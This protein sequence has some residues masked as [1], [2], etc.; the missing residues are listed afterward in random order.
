[1]KAIHMSKTNFVASLDN[2]TKRFG[3]H[4]ALDQLSFSLQPGELVAL[5]GANGAGK[6]TAIRHLLGLM[7]PT[8]GHVSLF[9]RPPTD[10]SA[11]SHIG[12]MLQTGDGG[13][14]ENLKVH[15]HIDLFSSYYPQP[16]ALEDTI[17]LAN[18]GDLANIQYK[19]LSGGQRQRVMFALALCGNPD[20]LFLD[21]PTVGLDVES[22]HALWTQI[23]ALIKARKT[24]LLTTHYI[25]EAEQLADRILVMQS[26]RIVAQGTSAEIKAAYNQRQIRCRTNL[27]DAALLATKGVLS[28]RREG[29]MVVLSSSN[30]DI[31]TRELILQDEE[32]ADLNVSQIGLQ[33]AF[34]ALTTDL[35]REH[36]A[37]SRI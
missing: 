3:G 1:M 9:G 31:T 35:T 36:T 21:E 24:V 37:K 32:L 16:L 28:L 33:E 30:P 2:V 10:R 17:R 26:G 34:L 15:E 23:R 20:L 29:V 11:R 6:T 5:L 13:L 12:A 4:T 7:Q 25:E 19:K 27:S 8:S 22:R 18:I 14:E